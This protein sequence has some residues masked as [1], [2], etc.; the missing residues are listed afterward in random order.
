MNK[1]T[2]VYLFLIFF[3]QNI[4]TDSFNY[5]SFNNHGVIGL[6]NM[7]T[8]RF[9]DES[10][11]GLTLYNGEPDQKITMTSYPYDWMEAS[12]FYMN[13]ENDQLCRG[14]AFGQNFCQ[15]YKDKGFN[16]K[17]R[18]KEEG[19]FPAVALGINDIAGT[20]FYSSEYIVG[21]YGINNIDFHLGLSWGTLNGS[22][23]SFKN[24]F[25]FI[26]DQFYDR[27][28]SY[29]Y[30]GGQFQPSRYFSGEKASPFFGIS[31]ALNSKILIKFETDNTLTPGQVCYKK[32]ESNYSFGIDYAV[33]K[34]FSI[35]IANERNNY[36][37]AKFVYKDNPKQAVKKYQYKTSE[38]IKPED[39]RYK[40]LIKNI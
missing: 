17:L 8:A 9:Y 13:I 6:V 23:N 33:N 39:D 28:N 32:A 37:S 38:T 4:Y 27:P 25:G 5:N 20:G 24:P 10:S 35:G 34:N 7:P 14:N 26:D 18:V 22:K 12:F 19:I 29:E 3:I 15:G 2:S 30:N 31:Y 1:Y 16:F 36:F 40:K 11:Y 21:S